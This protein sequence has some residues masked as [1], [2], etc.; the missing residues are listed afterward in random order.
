MVE[1]VHREVRETALREERGALHEEDDVIV[2]DDG[3]DARIDV[4]HGVKLSLDLAVVGR[5]VP[6][7]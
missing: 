5:Y 2:A 1:N 7:N 3:G 4:S 6:A